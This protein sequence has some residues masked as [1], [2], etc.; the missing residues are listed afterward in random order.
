MRSWNTHAWYVSGVLLALLIGTLSV[1]W[2]GVGCLPEIIS[3]A[4]G[5]S[6]LI[7]A[8]FAIIQSLTANTGAEATLGAV[9]EAAADLKETASQIKC[10]AVDLKGLSGTI[11][12][13]SEANCKA[14][15]YLSSEIKS[16]SKPLISNNEQ[17]TIGSVTFGSGSILMAALGSLIKSK[18]L[19]FDQIFPQDDNT[20]YKSGYIF[21]IRI[22]KLMDF[23]R[24][25]DKI[26]VTTISISTNQLIASVK[27][28]K[29]N[30]KKIGNM[31]YE[32]RL[33][34]VEK[35]FSYTKSW[36]S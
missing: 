4:V 30:T 29:L 23:E 20:N 2:N 21:G 9:R 14:I 18:P 27:S 36:G 1:Q 34:A 6:S 3:F 28:K 22:A 13:S 11:Y 25:G 24:E 16:K 7:L 12:E 26:K 8:I 32:H 31:T 35:F 33:D 17:D 15:A 19:S 10:S 5:L